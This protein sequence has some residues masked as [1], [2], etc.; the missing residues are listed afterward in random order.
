M[1]VYRCVAS[2]VF[3]SGETWSFRQHFNSSAAIA[4]VQGDWFSQLNSFWTNGS[5]G[6]ETLYPT[7]TSLTLSST[8]ALS[9]VPFREGAKQSGTMTLPGTSADDSLPEQVCILVS[10]R[11]TDVGERNRGRIH[12]PAPAETTATGGELGSTEA[13]RVSTA[14]GALYAGMRLAGHDPVVY[15]VAVSKVPTVDPVAQTLK[16]IVTEEVDRVLRS[17]RQRVKRRKAVY[18]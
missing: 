17:M 9:G 14:I 1:T 12:L 13:T 11:G 2:G 6:V 18:I 4:T 10:L 5:H 8:A 3:A 7:G 15:N 16:T